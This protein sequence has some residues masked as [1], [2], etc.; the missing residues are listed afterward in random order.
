MILTKSISRFGRN[1]PEMLSICR[2]LRR[3]GIDVFFFND[4]IHSIDEK[5]ELSISLMSAIAEG[6]SL[7]KSENI[8][9]GIERAAEDPDSPIYARPCYGYARKGR[10]ELEIVESEAE[11]VR[12]V[13][14]MYLSGKGSI[15]I[16]KSLEKDDI[17]SPTGNAIWPKATIEK[18]LRNE[19]YCGDVVFIKTFMG[20]FPEGK[21]RV[22]TGER[23]KY[24]FSDHHEGIISKEQFEAVQKAIEERKRKNKG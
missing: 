7:N 16:K 3:K 22:N 18:M 17:P 23:Q 8:K 13:F 1:T 2:R 6:D 10:Y 20:E 14:D 15:Y 4:G 11:V 12:R 21:R 19:K 9:W 24:S 5:G